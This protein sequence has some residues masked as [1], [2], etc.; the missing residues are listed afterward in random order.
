M[1]FDEEVTLYANKW[2]VEKKLVELTWG[3][4]SCFNREQNKVFIKPSGV[5]LDVLKPE[6]ISVLSPDGVLLAGKKPSVDTP[7]HLEIYKNFSE[8]NCIIHTHSKYATIFAQANMPIPCLG[9]THADYFCEQIPCVD[10][11]DPVETIEA[12]EQKTGARICNAFT[13]DPHVMSPLEVG[14]CLVNG[15]GVF[16]WDAE[17]EK[18][19]ERAYV[20]EIVA[21]MAFKTLMLNRDARLWEFIINKHFFRK[22]GDNK[23]YGQ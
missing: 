19:L 10:H 15:H 18:A 7:T 21:E 11:T 23:Y 4:V 13:I 5:N 2:I 8:I 16:S 3:N 6:E 1:S 20:L 22:H 17:V 12:Y 9:T 14:A